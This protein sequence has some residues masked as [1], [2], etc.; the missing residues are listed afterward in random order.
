MSVV[1][2]YH[3]VFFIYLDKKAKIKDDGAVFN[4]GS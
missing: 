4:L 2:V 3:F 1:Q